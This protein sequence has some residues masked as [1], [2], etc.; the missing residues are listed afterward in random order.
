MT[1]AEYLYWYCMLRLHGYTHE[2]AE[3]IIEEVKQK[4]EAG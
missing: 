4:A 3:Q 1:G 2:E